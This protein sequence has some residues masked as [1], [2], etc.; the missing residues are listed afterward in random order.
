MVSIKSN[1]F[2]NQSRP[3]D[4]AEIKSQP[5]KLQKITALMAVPCG[6]FS[7]WLPPP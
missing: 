6:F 1:H 7:R 2:L 5:F 4:H 3:S